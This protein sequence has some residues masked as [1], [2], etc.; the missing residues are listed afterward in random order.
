MGKVDRTL[1]LDNPEQLHVGVLPDAVSRHNAPSRAE[2]IRRAVLAGN[3]GSGKLAI[4]VVLDKAAHALA[5]SNAV[6][7]ALPTFTLKSKSNVDRKIALVLVDTKGNPITV[8]ASIQATVHASRAAAQ[9]VDTPPDM[10]NPA[11]FAAQA[12]QFLKGVAGV[13]IKEIVGQKLVDQGMMGI[14]S[15]GRAATEAPRLLI[16]SYSPGRGGA[17][18]KH[19]ALVGKGICFDAGGL[20]LKATGSISGMKMDMGGGAAML[21]AF[22]ALAQQKCPHK[23]TLLLCLAENAIDAGSYRPDD[24]LTLHSGKT[25]EINNTDAE[26]RLL[27]ADGVSYAARNLGADVILNAATLTGAQMISTGVL[28]AAVVSNK[29]SLEKSAVK[30]GLACG[31]LTHPLVFA[32]EIFCAEFP[33]KVADMTNSVSSRMNAQSSCA[34][35]F[36]YAQIEDQDVDWLHIDLAGPA[37][38]QGRGSGY[39]VALV[40]QIVMNELG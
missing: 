18:A 24:V 10:L 22:K 38:I 11:S 28:H 34:A 15:V 32:P 16:A 35:Q 14:Y 4:V 40:S 2:A 36:V 39:G 6:A 3:S 17:K 30:V 8:D 1:T 37:M 5:A 25:V 23:V 21:G 26:G 7:R 20:N 33:S 31:D 19:V 12:K 29:E 9:W 27:L 13:R